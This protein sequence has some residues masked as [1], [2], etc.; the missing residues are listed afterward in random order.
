GVQHADSVVVATNRDDTAV[1]VTLTARDCSFVVYAT[2]AHTRAGP[3]TEQARSRFARKT[4][5][6][7]AGRVRLCTP[8]RVHAGGSEGEGR[9][10]TVE[11]VAGVDTMSG[12]GGGGHRAK[13]PL[14][15]STVTADGEGDPLTACDDRTVGA[16]PWIGPLGSSPG[17][18]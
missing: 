1:L 6:R 4:W 2:A 14:S 3:R 10:F 7:C 11:G 12:T 16:L 5:S 17:L 8:S 18:S 15:V 13:M 9:S